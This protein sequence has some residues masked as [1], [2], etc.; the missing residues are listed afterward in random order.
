M[1]CR[2]L[3]NQSDERRR[4]YKRKYGNVVIVDSLD[5]VL[6][7]PARPHRTPVL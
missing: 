7:N 4:T 3:R 6:H 5:Q 2:M 1:A